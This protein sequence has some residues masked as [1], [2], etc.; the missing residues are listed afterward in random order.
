MKIIKSHYLSL[1]LF[2]FTF[3]FACNKSPIIEKQTRISKELNLIML[4]VGDLHN[5]GLNKFSSE[6]SNLIKNL[7]KLEKE[8]KNRIS[9]NTVFKNNS[10]QEGVI[11]ELLEETRTYF[12]QYTHTNLPEITFPNSIF[13]SLSFLPTEYYIN[14][15]NLSSN[16]IVETSP[17]ILSPLFEELVG[18]LIV[19]SSN[20]NS[21]NE[22]NSQADEI[23]ISADNYLTSDTEFFAI[24]MGIAIGKS[25]FAY[26]NTQ[27]NV[28]YW[29]SILA[30]YSSDSIQQNE[31]RSNYQFE[32]NDDIKAMATADL[33]G[34]IRGGIMGGTVGS[35]GGPAG[36]F[37]G[38]VGGAFYTGLRSSTLAGAWRVAKKYFNW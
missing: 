33:A 20:A 26:W 24:A 1:T 23:L 2:A 34:A 11:E 21:I 38:A 22:F 8:N 14:P 7:K 32:F 29:N 27:E 5:K 6:K 18:Q 17:I 36:T 30:T 3:L 19:I 9:N 13:D 15:N 16:Y 12:I 25:S 37:S 4:K 31:I 28:D 35:I 10:T